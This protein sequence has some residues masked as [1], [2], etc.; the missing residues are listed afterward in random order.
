MNG[1]KERK[2]TRIQKGM[3]GNEVGG[4]KRVLRKRNKRKE[5]T[6]ERENVIK[7]DKQG[8]REEWEQGKK[9]W[10]DKEEEEKCAKEKINEGKTNE[11][12]GRI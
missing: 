11:L 7:E 3:E 1:N 8:G 10:E 9:G 4:K 6:D 12:R 5:K 2:E